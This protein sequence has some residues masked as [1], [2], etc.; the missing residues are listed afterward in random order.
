MQ[1]LTKTIRLTVKIFGSHK[2]LWIP[3]IVIVLLELLF[4][5]MIWLAPHP[6]YSKIFAPP[7]R[8]FFSDRFL[9]YPWHL[10]FLFYAMKH[11]H[12]VASV[13]LGAFMSGIACVM[14]RQTHQSKPP[15]MRDALISKDVHYGRV[16]LLWVITWG[17]ARIFMESLS[18]FAPPSS[19]VM[20]VA[21][22][23]TIIIQALFV[24]AI[25]IAVFQNLIWRKAILAS[26]LETLRRPLSTLLVVTLPSIIVIVFAFTVSP[27]RLPNWMMSATPEIVFVFILARLVVWT[28][29]DALLTVAV[30]HLWLIHNSPEM[31]S[32][33]I[34][35]KKSGNITNQVPASKKGP[36]VA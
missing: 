33:P 1:A 16:L 22:T 14:V 31:L 25:P 28:V 3:F 7:I 29:A 8:F 13:V 4:I 26:I 21:L 30:C 11:T 2:L 35:D 19:W 23:A 15:S 32:N 27:G 36:A 9:H 12:L 6:P 18:R 24:Y 17:V 20:P 10:W 34:E 5:A